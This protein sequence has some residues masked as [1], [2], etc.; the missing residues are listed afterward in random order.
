MNPMITT[1]TLVQNAQPNSEWPA[2]WIKRWRS[3]QILHTTQ[4]IARRWNV[5][6]H[7][8]FLLSY[9][10]SD[11]NLHLFRGRRVACSLNSYRQSSQ[12][13]LFVLPSH[14]CKHVWWMNPKLPLQWQGEISSSTSAPQWQIRQKSL[15]SDEDESFFAC[16]NS[17][18][19]IPMR[20][21]LMSFVVEVLEHTLISINL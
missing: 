14:S 8:I 4:V 1:T 3:T 12:T 17:K 19:A 11:N 15:P 2:S 21:D 13:F 18:V 7:T 6:E 20:L 5:T 16:R 9:R 10:E